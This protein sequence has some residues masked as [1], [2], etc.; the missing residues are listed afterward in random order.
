MKRSR[1]LAS[2]DQ[3]VFYFGFP[4]GCCQSEDVLCLDGNSQ[5]KRSKIWFIHHPKSPMQPKGKKKSGLSMIWAQPLL[6][7]AVNSRWDLLCVSLLPCSFFFFFFL[8]NIHSLFTSPSCLWTRVPFRLSLFHFS[9]SY[10][11]QSTSL[12]C[13][14]WVLLKLHVWC[15][16]FQKVWAVLHYRVLTDEEILAG[17]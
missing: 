14:S 2:D 6:S 3:F 17:R 1:S 8:V 12:I 4:N 10:L 9:C 13:Q 7:A 16:I 11:K 15:P 5:R